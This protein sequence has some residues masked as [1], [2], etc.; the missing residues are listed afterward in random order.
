MKKKF[1]VVIFGQDP[2]NEEDPKSEGS[3]EIFDSKLDLNNWITVNCI[4]KVDPSYPDDPQYGKLPDG[5][6]ITVFEG[7]Q[8]PLNFTCS[9]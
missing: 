4:E 6:I 2:K 5:R 9:I 8:R 7:K 1:Y 3:V